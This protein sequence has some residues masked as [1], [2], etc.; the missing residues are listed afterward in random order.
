MNRGPKNYI[1]IRILHSVPKAQDKGDSTNHGFYRTLMF[2]YHMP[3]TICHELYTIYS[4]S[5][6]SL[7]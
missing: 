3:H 5:Y 6:R 7:C 4:I 2:F 1:N